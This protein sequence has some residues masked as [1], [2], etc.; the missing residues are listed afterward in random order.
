MDAG[1]N[2]W[3]AMALNNAWANRTLYGAMRG[4]TPDAFLAN[5]PG[6]FPSLCKTLN[7]IYEVDLYYL[8][9]LESG[10]RGLTVYDRDE[11]RDA[12]TLSVLQAEADTRFA[13]FCREMTLER[14][15]ETRVTERYEGRIEETVAALILHLVQHQVHHR[16][17]AH[18]QL[19]D[20][21][22]APPQLD[23]FYLQYDKAETARA[24]WS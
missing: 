18:V 6:F 3:L 7:H 17:Q 13:A 20:A 10:G 16:G 15:S 12:A 1:E 9:A 19:Q 4:L 11:V 24:Y 14:L 22:V 21:G 2:P 8:D 5:R 23:D